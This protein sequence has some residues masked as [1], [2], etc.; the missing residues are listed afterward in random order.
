MTYAAQ[1]SISVEQSQAE[2]VALVASY[3]H[4]A[5]SLVHGHGGQVV[6]EIAGERMTFTEPR[7]AQQCRSM[8]RSVKV[9]VHGRLEALA[10]GMGV[11]PAWAEL[12]ERGVPELALPPPSPPPQPLE[13]AAQVVRLAL[14]APA[15]QG[16]RRPGWMGNVTRAIEAQVS[17][18]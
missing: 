9:V 5:P 13:L 7:G 8:W 12:G 14:D 10:V 15:L 6:M 4:P 2:I 11:E 18:R 1:T 17:G 3:G 16:K